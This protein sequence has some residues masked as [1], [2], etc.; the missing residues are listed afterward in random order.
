[1]VDREVMCLFRWIAQNQSFALVILLTAHPALAD[2]RESSLVPE[3]QAHTSFY[4][5]KETSLSGRQSRLASSQDFELIPCLGYI[6]STQNNLRFRLE[7]HVRMIDYAITADVSATGASSTLLRTAAA[8]SG[9]A[10]KWEWEL[11]FSYGDAQV[12]DAPDLGTVHLHSLGV[13]KASASIAYPLIAVFTK[14]FKFGAKM[15]Y[16]FPASSAGSGVSIV[17]GYGSG[18]FFKLDFSNATQ[19]AFIGGW[20]AQSIKT[21]FGS[22]DD[23]SISAGFQ[24]SFPGKQGKKYY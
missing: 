18:I 3:V 16:F 11:G 21:N 4:S 5:I 6:L 14:A 15:T 20:T 7:E 8:L 23:T 13:S 10:G 24:L 12:L 22:Q 2:R 9:E 1:M 17:S 19:V